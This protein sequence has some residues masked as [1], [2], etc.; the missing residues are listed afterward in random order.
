MEIVE[1]FISMLDLDTMD[2]AE[3]GY[4]SKIFYMLMYQYTEVMYNEKL[5]GLKD[6]NLIKVEPVVRYYDM[7]KYGFKGSYDSKVFTKEKISVICTNMNQVIL[8]DSSDGSTH[9][10]KPTY[11]EFKQLLELNFKD[12]E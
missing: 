5:A 4:Q 10:S 1:G 3:A 9:I 6:S 8:F 7:K 2:E 11:A 12:E